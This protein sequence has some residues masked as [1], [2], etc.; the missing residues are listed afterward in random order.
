MLDGVLGHEPGVIAAATGHHEH[1]GDRA[2]LLVG[3]VDL[4][5]HQG[6]VGQHSVEERVGHGF[7][8]LVHL[9]GHEVVVAV[10]AGCIEVP[11]DVQGLRL[12]RVALEIR[13]RDRPRAE[14]GDAVIVEDEEV[15]GQPE[16]GG[17]VRCQEGRPFVD[18]HDQRRD[19]A[20]G[21]DG[22]GVVR[23]H[24]R[25][26]ERSA[27]PAQCGPDRPHDAL[28]RGGGQVGLDEVGQDLGV[29]LGL[30]VV[31]VGDQLVGQLDVILDDAVVDQCQAAGAVGVRVGVVFVGPPVGGPPGVPDAG[32][33][34]RRCVVG[35]FGEVVERTGAVGGPDPPHPISGRR[36]HHGQTGRVVASILQ[37]GESLD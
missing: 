21:H 15:V 9:F 22:I 13:H 20:G 34:V 19:S 12:H 31:A 32:G 28:R 23:M 24:H 29:G 7:G 1:L 3:D 27:H 8:L 16:D 37:A 5:E 4:V 11:V 6:P 25:Q 17:D 35:A 18:P 14:F 30:E 36:A 2:E 10:L 33:R 26:R